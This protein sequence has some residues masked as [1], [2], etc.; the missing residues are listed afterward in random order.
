MKIIF[1]LVLFSTFN[2]SQMFAQLPFPDDNSSYTWEYIIWYGWTN[3]CVERIVKTGESKSICGGRFIEI[4]DCDSDGNDCY[5]MGGYFVQGNS[6]YVRNT[7]YNP[8]QPSTINCEGNPILMYDFGSSVGD[9][10]HCGISNFGTI[11]ERNFI[12]KDKVIKE[13]L[14][15]N[16]QNMSMDYV[17]YPFTPISYDAMK[18]IEGI[19]SLLH[20]F[21]SLLNCIGDNC[22]VERSLDRVLQNG[23]VIF[24]T[25]NEDY[26][27]PCRE[28]IG[29][30]EIRNENNLKISP[31]P[32]S[33][34][35]Q[36]NS[37]N[38]AQNVYNLDIVDQFGRIVLKRQGYN[39]GGS[40]DVQ[41]LPNGLYY[42]RLQ[43]EK[44]GFSTLKL[45][46]N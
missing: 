16:R 29:V 14:G 26:H 18:W 21:Y 40:V 39:I 8:G 15:V 30:V 43:L 44:G 41:G 35:F 23:Q 32:S 17:L 7:K 13:N 1:S 25:P 6:V 22:E 45:A 28:T 11:S 19:G 42:V 5:L 4:F 27:L 9:T 37:P 36:I 20:P 12:V 33:S 10:L 34:S 2:L 38:P 46:I 24:Y 3:T 31:N